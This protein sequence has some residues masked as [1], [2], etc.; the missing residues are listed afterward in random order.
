MGEYPW[1]LDLQVLLLMGVLMVVTGGLWAAFQRDIGRILGYAIII[2]LGH[3]LLA[4]SQPDGLP[5]YMALF[6]PRILAFAVWALALSLLRSRSEDLK[7]V[8]VQGLG[9]LYPLIVLGVLAANFS[10]IGFPLL[11]SFPV[12]SALLGRL[13]QESAILALLTLLGSGGLLV[14]GLRSFAVFVMGPDDLQYPDMRFD[15]L[16]Q[17]FLIVG[18][19]AIMLVGI[20]PHWFF[21]IFSNITKINF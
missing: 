20:F 16:A 14:G 9:R 2:E 3:S 6:M 4:I 7:F 17:V 15:R 1:L 10:V 13:V 11:A 12:L 5:I 8:S 19:I 21:S 18:M